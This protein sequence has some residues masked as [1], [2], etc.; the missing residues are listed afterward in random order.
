MNRGTTDETPATLKFRM[1][2]FDKAVADQGSSTS[3][4]STATQSISELFREADVIIYDE[5]DDLMEHVEEA[6]PDLYTEF[7][8]AKHINDRGTRHKRADN[9]TPAPPPKASN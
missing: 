1:D 3:Q 2:A 6:Y 4:Q 5:M 8:E 7:H 9:L